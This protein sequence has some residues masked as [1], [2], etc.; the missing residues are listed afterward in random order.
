MDINIKLKKEHGSKVMLG[1]LEQREGKM[2]DQ[3]KTSWVHE[4]WRRQV[5][6]HIEIKRALGVGTATMSNH[7]RIYKD[8]FESSETFFELAV[9]V[10][11][12]LSYVQAGPTGSN[13]TAGAPGRAED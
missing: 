2:K 3:P 8:P 12:Q 9:A 7:L 6:D 5:M 11:P 1:L 13:R 4:F 10:D